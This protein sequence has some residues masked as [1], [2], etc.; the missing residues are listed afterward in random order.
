MHEQ[1]TQALRALDDSL[2]VAGSSKQNLLKVT[3]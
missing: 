2:W 3:L 1:T